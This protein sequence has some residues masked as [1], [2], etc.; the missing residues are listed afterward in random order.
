VRGCKLEGYCGG[1]GGGGVPCPRGEEGA[2]L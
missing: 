2:I 1:G